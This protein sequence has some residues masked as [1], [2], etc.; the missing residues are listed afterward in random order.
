MIVMTVYGQFDLIQIKIL[1]PTLGCGGSNI[2]T[3]FLKSPT[4]CPAS[5][6]LGQG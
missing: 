1:D 6:G 3:R 5:L 2:G 4:E